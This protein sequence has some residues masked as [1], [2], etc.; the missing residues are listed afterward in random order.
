ME[1]KQNESA[2]ASANVPFKP[3]DRVTRCGIEGPTG[4]VQNVRIESVRETIKQDGE[5]PPGV[6]VTVLWDNGTVSHF[7]PEGLEKAS[8]P[9]AELSAL[10]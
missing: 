10:S 8:P 2:A 5:E 1:E 3:G 9:A 6:A 4:T 7:V